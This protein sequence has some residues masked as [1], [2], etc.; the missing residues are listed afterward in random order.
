MNIY[1]RLPSDCINLREEQRDLALIE[2]EKRRNG[3]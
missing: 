1:L 2:M 3:R